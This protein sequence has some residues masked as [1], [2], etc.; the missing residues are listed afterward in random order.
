LSSAHH[1]GRSSDAA[2]AGERSIVTTAAFEI[3]PLRFACVR[4][5]KTR[6]LAI[7]GSIPGIL[8]FGITSPAIS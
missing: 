6:T 8:H 2:L 3:L 7:M 5:T 4:M 1:L